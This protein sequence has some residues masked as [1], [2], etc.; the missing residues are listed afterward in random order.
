MN[1]YSLGEVAR[2]LG[3]N[4]QTVSLLAEK[5]RIPYR[6]IGNARAFTQEELLMLSAN[7]VEKKKGLPDPLKRR[8]YTLSLEK[9]KRTRVTAQNVLVKLEQIERV[10]QQKLEALGKQE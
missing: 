1:V 2:K 5:L 8:A 7:W 3:G 4:R 9:T 6:K 10:L